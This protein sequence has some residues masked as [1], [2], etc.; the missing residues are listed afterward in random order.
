M[1]GVYR[2]VLGGGE[3]YVMGVRMAQFEA[4]MGIL[5]QIVIEISDRSV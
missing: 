5:D 4:L 1:E 2:L 3:E